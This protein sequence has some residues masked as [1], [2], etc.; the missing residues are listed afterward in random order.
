MHSNPLVSIIIPNY[1]SSDFVIDTL[2]SIEQ[3]TYLNWECIIVDDHSTD[4]SVLLISNYIKEK[5]KFQLLLRPID[6]IKGANS[7][8]NYGLQHASGVY[9]NWF[10]SDDIMLFNFLEFKIRNAENNDMIIATGSFVSHD[11]QAQKKIELFQP[12]SLYKEYVMWKLKILTPSIMFK[13]EFLDKNQY[14]FNENIHKGQEMEL[15]SK[16]FFDKKYSS[17]KLL[18]EVTFLYR[19]HPN[20]S[21]SINQTYQPIY[22]FSEAQTLLINFKRSL[23]LLDSD[24]IHSRY[25]L[26]INLLKKS[27]NNSDLK[28]VY[29]ITNE[30]ED[31][32]GDKNKIRFWLLKRIIKLF[33]LIK[34]TWIRWEY[35]F[36]KI[37]INY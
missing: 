32:I 4:N 17:F 7:C 18:N 16:I 30:L 24:L 35:P 26:L 36:K 10:D 22:K 33:L 27:T 21:T 29:L 14:A 31:C 23:I 28:L 25:R 12:N 15:F 13:K 8:R 9:I 3:Q 1:N 34:I 2:K 20:S 5:S 11:L 6:K 37:N 19:S